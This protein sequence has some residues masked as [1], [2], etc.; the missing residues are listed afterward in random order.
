MI[1]HHLLNIKRILLHLHKIPH[2]PHHNLNN[3]IVVCGAVKLRADELGH[4][5]AGGG[6]VVG[7][8]MLVLVCGFLWGG[9]WWE[10]VG[11]S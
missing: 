6:G 9:Y 8:G 11:L 7:L 3:A 1:R 2:I 4:Q 5:G 10:G